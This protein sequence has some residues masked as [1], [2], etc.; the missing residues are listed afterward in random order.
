MPHLTE[1]YH[2]A[3]RTIMWH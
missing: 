3:S 2:T 1:E